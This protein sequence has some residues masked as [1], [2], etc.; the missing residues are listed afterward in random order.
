MSDASDTTRKLRVLFWTISAV[1]C[2]CWLL[3]GYILIGA[4]VRAFS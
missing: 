1:G 3:A 2:A 4:L